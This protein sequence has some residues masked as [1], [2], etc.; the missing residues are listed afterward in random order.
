MAAARVVRADSAVGALPFEQLE[1]KPSDNDTVLTTSEAEGEATEQLIE[2][3]SQVTTV[4]ALGIAI[5]V[6]YGSVSWAFLQLFYRGI[7]SQYYMPLWKVYLHVQLKDAA[8]YSVLVS[9]VLT[10]GVSVILSTVARAASDEG[11]DFGTTRFKV[12]KGVVHRFKS[13]NESMVANFPLLATAVVLSSQGGV[14]QSIRA[15][16]AA[17]A[18]ASQIAHYV[19]FITGYDFVRTLAHAAFL[20][21]CILLLCASAVPGFSKSVLQQMF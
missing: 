18:V 7:L 2:R 3:A 11:L 12:Y 20:A 21:P 15:Q 6:L 19:T 13:A 4:F 10:Y 14:S 16:F 5:P 17:W 1:T 9:A 8:T